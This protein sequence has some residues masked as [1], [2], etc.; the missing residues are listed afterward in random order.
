MEPPPEYDAR[1]TGIIL[2]ALLFLFSLRVLGQ[3]LVAFLDVTWLPPMHQWYSGLMSYEYLIPS[4][5]AIIILYGKIC[6][7]ILSGSGYFAV[8]RSW[9]AG[10]VRHF[11]YA[12][13]AGMIARYPVQ[14][15]LRPELRWFGQTIPIFFHWVLA[16][17]LIVFGHFHKRWRRPRVQD[18][19]A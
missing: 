16:S 11:G 13:L 3:M 15:A 7:D 17:F 8:H 4:Q 14:M 18:A 5:F 1:R 6:R 10:G 2:S 12:Y 19:S 9:F